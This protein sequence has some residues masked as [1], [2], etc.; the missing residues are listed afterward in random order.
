ML[1]NQP[2][3]FDLSLCALPFASLVYSADSSEFRS[4]PSVCPGSIGPDGVSVR[5][6]ADST[7]PWTP[8][9]QGWLFQPWNLHY[10]TNPQN[11]QLRN[12]QYDPTPIDPNNPAGRVNDLFTFQIP[13]NDTVFT[14]YGV[15]TPHPKYP[16]VLEYAGTGLLEGAT[17]EYVNLAWGC[18]ENSVPYYVTYSSAAD[19]TNT[20]AGIDIQT[21]SYEDIGQKTLAALLKAL[22]ETGNKEITDLANALKR[23]IDDGGRDHLPR[24]TTCDD[25]CKSNEIL[26]PIIGANA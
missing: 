4:S 14:S 10:A 9:L 25:Y 12:L 13:N 11:L 21:V 7:T 26:R 17:S 5:A 1:L 23:T 19:S 6:T 18:D 20:P 2:F 24:V 22:K 15:D 8:P 16:A 3:K